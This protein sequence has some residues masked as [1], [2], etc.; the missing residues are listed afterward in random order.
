[1][2][3]KCRKK[4]GVLPP[5]T[6]PAAAHALGSR[7]SRVKQRCVLLGGSGG[8]SNNGKENGNYCINIGF[9]V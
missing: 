2:L 6:S 1:M 7:K 3:L 5:M 8:L 9:R 4:E